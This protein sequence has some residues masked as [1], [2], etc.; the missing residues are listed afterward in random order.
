MTAT[1]R[2]CYLI[3]CSFAVSE[4]AYR[5]GPLCGEIIAEIKAGES[6]IAPL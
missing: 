1:A 5:K 2:T 6:S 4:A 3:L